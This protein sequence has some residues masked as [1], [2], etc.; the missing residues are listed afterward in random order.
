M[1]KLTFKGLVI[2]T[3]SMVV[4]G[5]DILTVAGVNLRLKFSISILLVIV[6]KNN[7]VRD[8]LLTHQRRKKSQTNEIIIIKE[9]SCKVN[10]TFEIRR[11]VKIKLNSNNPIKP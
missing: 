3:V 4:I 8:T 6:Q 7:E 2:V 9:I 10:A 5:A 11:M 1:E